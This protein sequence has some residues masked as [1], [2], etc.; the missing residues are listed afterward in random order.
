MRTRAWQRR[1]FVYV[2]ISQ[3][4]AF[5]CKS[6]AMPAFLR[7]RAV[8]VVSIHLLDVARLP[9]FVDCGF[10]RAVE[11]HDREI[12]LARH[13]REPVSS[14]A[15]GCSWTEIEVSA[16]VSILRRLVARTE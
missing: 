9:G 6:V 3:F 14:L 1:D 12:P 11:S 16:A 5:G 13:G 7:W 4:R 10:G 8:T 15:L 2:W